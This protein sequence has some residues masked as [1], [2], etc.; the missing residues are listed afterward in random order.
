M[1]VK[2]P[3]FPTYQKNDVIQRSVKRCHVPVWPKAVVLANRDTPLSFRAKHLLID[4]QSHQKNILMPAY[5]V[6][7]GS[8]KR[9]R[10][11]CG[12]GPCAET[13]I[14][15]RAHTNGQR[16]MA[17]LKNKLFC[18]CRKTESVQIPFASLLFLCLFQKLTMT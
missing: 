5:T 2:K 12:S 13:S 8:Q 6:S 14:Q 18:K 4:C 9:M 16:N 7:C 1:S 17:G 10:V 3:L 11:I 15:Q